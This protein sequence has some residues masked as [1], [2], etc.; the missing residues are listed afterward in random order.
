MV[1]KSSA[2]SAKSLVAAM[3]MRRG[4]KPEAANWSP[5]MRGLR[6]TKDHMKGLLSKYAK[7]ASGK[8]KGAKQLVRSRR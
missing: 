1:G 5:A 7:S 4:G 2:I 6:E 3:G 8:G